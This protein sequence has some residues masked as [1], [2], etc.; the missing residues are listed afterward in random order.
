MPLRMLAGRAQQSGQYWPRRV[1]MVVKLQRAFEAHAQPAC[2]A[3][4]ARRL[5]LCATC[6]KSSHA[7]PDGEHLRENN[8]DRLI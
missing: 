4:G 6:W 3:D 8:S 1:G 5:S 7:V 2:T